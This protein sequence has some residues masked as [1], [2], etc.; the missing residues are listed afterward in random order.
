MDWPDA[1]LQGEFLREMPVAVREELATIAQSRTFLAGA[2]VFREGQ[3]HDALHIVARGR[4]RLEIEVPERGRMPVMTVGPGDILGWSPVFGHS[5]MTAT[6]IAE[7]EVHTIALPGEALRER[8]QT[9][10]DI[11]YPVMKQLALAL[12]RRL[13]ATRR[14]M[15]NVIR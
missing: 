9:R 3:L 4:V 7:D 15:F 8:C 12:A 1:V 5:P 14:E 11:G 13:T 10:Y 6:A 2:V